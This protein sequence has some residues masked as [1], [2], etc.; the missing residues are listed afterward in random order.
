MLN[1]GLTS[2]FFFILLALSAN[3]KAQPY[4]QVVGLGFG[5][6]VAHQLEENGVR[7]LAYPF[8]WFHTPFDG[9]AWFIVNQGKEFLNADKLIVAG[10]YPGDPVHLQV[11]EIV[12]G[13]VS[14]HDFLSNMSNYV[15]IKAKYDRRIK[16]F[17]DLLNSDQRVLFVSQSYTRMQIENLDGVL[18]ILYPNLSY[19]LVAINSTP[20]YMDSWELDRIE[21][22][23]ME[24]TPGDWRGNTPRWK[25]I[26]SQFEVVPVLQ[27]RPWEERW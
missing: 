19:T 18:Q 1:K 20:E 23:Y 4:D 7:K 27:A 10:P 15:E 26:L 3:I 21:N 17:F 12:Y 9:L 22:F 6:Q 8:D 16:R 5:C 25:E 24:E 14:Y 13:I 2:F 11:G